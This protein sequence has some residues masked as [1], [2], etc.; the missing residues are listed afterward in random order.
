[1]IKTLLNKQI[2]FSQLLFFALTSSLGLG[3]LLVAFQLFIDTQSL[4]STSNDLL[5]NQNL[6]IYKDLGRDNAFTSTEI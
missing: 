3:I 1:M 5:G 6:I 4:F 2:H